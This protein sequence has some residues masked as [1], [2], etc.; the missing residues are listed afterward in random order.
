[1]TK[2]TSVAMTA[3]A[4]G[5]LRGRLLRADGQEDICVATY[6]P[7]T[8]A[9]RRT[10]LIR[11]I[12]PPEPGERAVHGNASITGEYVLRA[13][14]AAQAR[15]EGLALCHSH[16]HAAGWQPMSEPDRDA[17]SSF[18]NLARE[19]TGLPLVGLTLAGRDGRWSG[20]H[21]DTGA[22][23]QVH[24]TACRNVR[25][26]GDQYAVSWN[27]SKVPPP[28]V[29]PS[30]ARSVSCWGQDM[31]VDLARRSVL[32]VG[33]GSVGLE[34]ATRLAATGLT[35]I[36]LMDF[37]TVELHNLDRLIGVTATDAWLRR[38]KAHA[39]RRLLAENATAASPALTAWEYSICEPEGFRVALD[40][41]LVFCC[42][43][44]PWPRAVLNTMAY[45]HLIPVIDGGIAIDVFPDGHGMR[46]ATWRSHV[47][48]SGRPCMSCNGQLDLGAVTADRD[49]SLDD[50]A[51]I[52][53][54]GIH[55][56]GGQNVAAL[57]I[58]A[59]SALLAQ[60]VSFNV[61]PGGIG[62]PGPLQYLLSTHTIEHLEAEGKT[63]CPV[64]DFTAAGDSGPCLTG[65]HQA[66]ED[67]RRSRA[68][69]RLPLAIR[70]GRAVD[71]V[72]WR[73]RSSLAALG[74]R[75]LARATGR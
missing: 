27:D 72:A 57:S 28:A 40:F 19:I 66:A 70:V 52:L 59:S 48:R 45:S 39:V 58:G 2:T 24:A 12:V 74:Q 67:R 15:G 42:V 17:E 13:A 41:D 23:T 50:P 62:D 20:R 32:V 10:A 30:H 16:P 60:Y 75:S 4:E 47:I 38:P 44:R 3:T 34:V 71:D 69:A 33:T 64:E 55:A 73:V 9:A 7:S 68:P 53:G 8:G 65:C 1:M 14:A 29:Q 36:G 11:I 21:W 22:G 31:H 51:Y 18:A 43:D 56:E 37:D 46:N 54:G 63:D 6:R 5:D 25:V 35:A 49:G 26:I 61:A